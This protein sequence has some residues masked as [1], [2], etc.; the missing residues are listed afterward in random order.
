MISHADAAWLESLLATKAKAL[1]QATQIGAGLGGVV[2]ARLCC[3][4]SIPVTDGWPPQA[5]INNRD[6]V[7]YP[8]IPAAMPPA[9]NSAPAIGIKL[10]AVDPQPNNPHQI[11]E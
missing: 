1:A 11:T 10:G 2:D 8:Q 9:S 5:A 7:E 4:E 3:P 6:G